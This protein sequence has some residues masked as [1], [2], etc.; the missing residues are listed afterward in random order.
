[1]KGDKG[2]YLHASPITCFNRKCFAFATR[3]S[4]CAKR[5]FDPQS[6]ARF[7][8]VCAPHGLCRAPQ[9]LRLCY[10]FGLEHRRCA[11]WLGLLESMSNGR[12][13]FRLRLNMTR[14]LVSLRAS[15]TSVAIN[16]QRIPTHRVFKTFDCH[17]ANASR[18]DNAQREHGETPRKDSKS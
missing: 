2:N 7:L 12:E 18:N 5:C 17:E 9:R 4:L 10:A 1:F 16:E 3:L 15:V 14:F 13:M 6:L 8:K 11:L